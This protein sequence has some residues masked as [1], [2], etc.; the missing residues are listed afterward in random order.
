M[1]ALLAEHLTNPELEHGVRCVAIQ[2]GPSLGSM[3]LAHRGDPGRAVASARRSEAFEESPGPVEGQ[4]A[5]AL[6]AAGAV[7]DGQALAR[8]V[9][10]RALS[11]RWHE[12]ARAMI[13]A[14]VERSAWDEL[15]SLLA[16]IE[17]IRGPDPMLSAY[18][19]RAEG[20][21]LAASGDTSG[22]RQPLMRALDAFA[23]FPHVFEAARTKE[24]LALVSDEPER[25][26]LLGE[27]IA[28]YRSLGATPH[29]ER[30]EGLLTHR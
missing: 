6:V 17:P 5:E 19:E 21:A 26:R 25:L 11:W 9:L 2:S 13:T 22:A 4:I 30:A 10:D 7:D 29:L 24:A 8:D 3:V 12:A 1:E 18:A 28:A 16:T 14:L 27:A 23:E 15:Q 20:Q